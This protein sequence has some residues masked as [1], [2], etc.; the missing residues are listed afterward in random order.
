VSLPEVEVAI[1]GKA[2]DLTP[3]GEAVDRMCEQTAKLPARELCS[4]EIRERQPFD[5]VTTNI[6]G[7]GKSYDYGCYR[8]ANHTGRHLGIVTTIAGHEEHW[9]VW[10]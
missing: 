10:S 7:L 9:V 1:L 2:D 4:S 3:T 6:P 5:D 8:L